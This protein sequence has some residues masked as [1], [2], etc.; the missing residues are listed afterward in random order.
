MHKI[1]CLNK[2]GFNKYKNSVLLDQQKVNPRMFF[3]PWPIEKCLHPM[4]L[5]IFLWDNEN[6]KTQMQH[7]TTSLIF[8]YSAS[9]INV[10]SG[11]NLVI[12][13]EPWFCLFYFI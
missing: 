5:F 11:F 8:C 1:I 7:I 2:D 13:Q 6:A 12:E 3:T 9:T 10:F 4:L